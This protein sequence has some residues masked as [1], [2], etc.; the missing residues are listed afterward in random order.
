MADAAF[1]ADRLISLARAM[2]GAPGDWSLATDAAWLARMYAGPETLT[3]FWERPTG[4]LLASASILAGPGDRP[5]VIVTSMLRA[6]SE[7]LWTEQWSWLEREIEDAVR[8]SAGP[9]AVLAVSEALGDA[10]AARWTSV[11]FDLVFEEHTMELDLG[12]HGGPTRPR[13][14]E[15]ARVLDWGPEA[16]AAS[17][18]V[19]ESAFRERP[20]FP[21][22]T[23]SEWADRLTGDDDFLPEASLCARIDGVP[24]GYV[25]SRRGWIDQVGVVPEQRRRGLARALLSEVAARQRAGG[26]SRLW[27]HVNADNPGARAVWRA[28]GWSMVGRRGRF[29]RDAHPR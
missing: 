16:A 22:W 11:G 2:P 18:A 9:P 21:G 4:E 1:D 8:A 7:D 15:G 13:W 27:L 24:A 28:L 19:Y 29:E 14:P 25:V 20:R 6:G 26:E 5:S 10:E 17:F 3:R 12:A 23:R